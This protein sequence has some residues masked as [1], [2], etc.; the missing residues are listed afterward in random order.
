MTVLTAYDLK[1]WIQVVSFQCGLRRVGQMRLTSM[2]ISTILMAA[3]PLSL[4]K[5]A[6]GAHG[7]EGRSD[8][9]RQKALDLVRARR[10]FSVKCWRGPRCFAPLG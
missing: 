9:Q 3:I 8:K 10:Q 6:V 7:P 1:P 4:P 2:M 5:S